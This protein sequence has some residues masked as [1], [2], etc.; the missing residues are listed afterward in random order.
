MCANL[1]FKRPLPGLGQL[2]L[3]SICYRLG[4]R[5]LFQKMH[6]AFGRMHVDIDRCRVEFY[7]MPWYLP[8]ALSKP[9]GRSMTLPEV[10][11]WRSAFG[12]NASVTSFYGLLDSRGLYQTIC[13]SLRRQNG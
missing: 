13:K 8:L 5:L 2:G 6:L 10:Y 7:A 4:D 1:V 11:K 12:K 3:D 9:T